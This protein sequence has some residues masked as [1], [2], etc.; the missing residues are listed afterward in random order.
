MTPPGRPRFLASGKVKDV[1]DMG[2]GTLMFRF[3]DRVSAFDVKFGDMIPRKGEALCKFAQ[4]W[5]DALP[6]PNHFVR[7]LSD[8]EMLVKRM[9]MIPLECVVR[10]YL[11]GSFMDRFGAGK[12]EL[13]P[14]SGIALASKLGRPVFDPTTKSEHDAPVGR[15]EA[16]SAG[17]LT[18][19][20]YELLQSRSLAIYGMM[21][22]RARDAGFVLADLKLEFGVLDGQILLGDSIGP[23]EYRL[24]P[25]DSYAPGNRQESYDKQILRDWLV[26]TGW[27]KRFGDDLAAGVK[28]TPPAIPQDISEMMSSRYVSSYEALTGA[29]L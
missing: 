19:E 12:V 18:K 2:D 10:G 20:Q 11:Y 21:A 7:R 26:E 8:V 9:D 6:G 4:Y 25:A 17:L 24:W 16:I 28:S 15:E 23:D 14:G 13:P 1:Y 29:P 3:S 27:A 5:F 22:A